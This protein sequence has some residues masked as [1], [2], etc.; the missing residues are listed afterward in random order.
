MQP[1]QTIFA[2]VLLALCHSPVVVA[3]APSAVLDDIRI[4]HEASA[5]LI[6][7]PLSK[8]GAQYRA[9]IVKLQGDLQKKADLDGLIIIKAELERF[10]KETAPASEL[11]ALDSISRLQKV[12]QSAY[13][14]KFPAVRKELNAAE[15]DYRKKLEG[16]MIKLTKAG[17][18]EEAVKIR[19]AL[20]ELGPPDVGDDATLETDLVFFCDFSAVEK[21]V[22][23]D[24][25]KTGNDGQLIGDAKVLSLSGNRG[26]H[27]IFD[28]KGD[29]IKIP[30]HK[31][32]SLTTDG[33]IS[34]WVKP[35]RMSDMV[36]LVSKY[37]KDKCWTF[38]NWKEADRRKIA[39][40]DHAHTQLS[41]T[42][43]KD[44][45]WT[46]LVATFDKDKVA[47]YFDGKLD[48]E[49]KRPSPIPT[50]E[51]NVRIGSCYG[52]RYFH[53]AVDDVRIYRRALSAKE[54]AE[55]FDI[56]S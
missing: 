1:R 6:R 52:G 49:G 43:L 51:S 28:G 36:G 18:V 17:E 22:I 34:I 13:D 38:R 45:R 3:Q 2:L 33:T 48:S 42:E 53:G 21:D 9:A 35:K 23:R 24:A 27:A 5:G 46:H 8:L 14:E 10:D 55:L 30:H 4:Q 11:S 32:L 16:M 31:S 37:N 7:K 19:T 25:S 44:D 20:E 12:Y 47:V 15:S 54:V 56:E 41:E 40:G 29:Y 26:Q 50:N 39:I